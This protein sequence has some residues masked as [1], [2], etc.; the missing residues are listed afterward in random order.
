MGVLS[1]GS[2]GIEAGIVYS[3]PVRT[4]NFDYEIVQGLT[5][6]EFSRGKMDATNAE[7][8]EEREEAFAVPS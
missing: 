8:R 3:Y 5:I 2:Y 7:L 1:D 6:D 4:N